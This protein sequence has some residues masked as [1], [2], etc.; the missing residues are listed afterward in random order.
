VEG[1]DVQRG[2]DIA[3]GFI[4]FRARSEFEVR[5][6]LRK[7]DLDR[8]VEDAV[9]DRLKDMS[10]LDDRRF[11]GAYARDQVVGWKRGPFRVLRGLRSLGVDKAIAQGAVEEVVAENDLHQQAFLLA[12]KRWKRVS[13]TSDK[14]KAKKKIFD[15]LVRRGYSHEMSRSIVDRLEGLDDE[16]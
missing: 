1:D 6:R 15:Y 9:V 12:S 7:A 8:D 2:V 3:V 10:L 13:A 4:A 5:R 11:A 14:L 16:S